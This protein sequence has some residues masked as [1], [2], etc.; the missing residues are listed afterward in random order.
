M[1]PLEVV[2]SLGM[3]GL[4]LLVEKIKDERKKKKIS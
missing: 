4:F 2:V 1:E 3:V